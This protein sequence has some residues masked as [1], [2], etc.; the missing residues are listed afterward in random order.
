[1]GG[2]WFSTIEAL[3]QDKMLNLREYEASVPENV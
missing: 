2:Y 1:M 3:R